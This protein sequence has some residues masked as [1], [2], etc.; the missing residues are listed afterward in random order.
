[1]MFSLFQRTALRFALITLLFFGAFAHANAQNTSQIYI[2]YQDGGNPKLGSYDP[3]GGQ[4]AEVLNLTGS[5][6][7]VDMRLDSGHAFLVTADSLFEV[8]VD[9][10]PVQV[11]SRSTLEASAQPQQLTLSR[12]YIL[13]A[14]T[15]RLEL[16][17][18]NDGQFVGVINEVNQQVGGMTVVD[19]SAYVAQNEVSGSDSIPSFAVV[20]LNTASWVRDIPLSPRNQFIGEVLSDDLLVYGLSS[21]GIFTYDIN[22]GNADF[23]RILPR[24]PQNII[25]S[26]GSFGAQAS[27]LSIYAEGGPYTTLDTMGTNSIQE[28]KV[29]GNEAYVLA[30]DSFFRFTFTGPGSFVKESAAFPGA[31]AFSLALT[32]KQVL[33]GNFYGQNDSNLYFFDRADLSFQGAAR[34]VFLKPN[35]ILTDG[36]QTAYVS[37]N[38]SNANFADSAGYILKI[39]IANQSVTDTLF[40]DTIRPLGEQYLV[41]QSLYALSDS[42]YFKVDPATGSSSFVNLGVSVNYGGYA[43]QR[44]RW[45][46]TLYAFFDGNLGKYNLADEQF[47]ARDLTDSLVDV[48]TLD[49]ATARIHAARRNFTD[50]GNAYVF[51]QSGNLLDSYITGTSSEYMAFMDNFLSDTVS[52]GRVVINPEN[53][54][55]ALLEETL[56]FLGE[57]KGTTA[58]SLYAYTPSQALNA[59]FSGFA[60]EDSLFASAELA[61]DTIAGEIVMGLNRTDGTNT[62]LRYSDGGQQEDSVDL[63]SPVFALGVDYTLVTSLAEATSARGGFELYPNPATEALFVEMPYSDIEVQEMRL[64]NT[65]GQLLETRQLSGAGPYR[66]SVS[67]LEAGLYIIELDRGTHQERARFLKR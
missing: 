58:L 16:Y 38:L 22:N 57:S 23:Q 54:S 14:Y 2:G 8:A 45:A 17:N 19:D 36:P 52:A 7:I 15:Q 60:L 25:S 39:D 40:R 11:V 5:S 41:G 62:L 13:V 59:R 24:L 9:A 64:Y 32:D 18:R 66:L 44:Y 49:T 35:D 42:G 51:N 10:N 1:M 63:N 30:Q 21:E 46:D 50:S 27:N 12:Q 56:Y 67:S 31:S 47:I 65:F 26:G 20:D 53:R 34:D 55:A 3:V 37:Q 28:M 43:S 61:A 48:F 6:A 4:I 29:V 33:I